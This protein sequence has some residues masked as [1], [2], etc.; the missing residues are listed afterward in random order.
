MNLIEKYYEG[1][2][3]QYYTYKVLG[4][5]EVT[6]LKLVEADLKEYFKRWRKEMEG[7]DQ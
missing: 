2:E 3:T 4:F 6:A 5:D 1:F 7:E